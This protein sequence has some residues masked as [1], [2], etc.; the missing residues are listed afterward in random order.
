MDF[1]EVQAQRYPELAGQYEALGNLFSKKLWHELTEVLER[2]VS[3]DAFRREN[4][5]EELYAEFITK[6]ENRLSPIKLAQIV[7]IIGQKFNNAQKSVTFLSSILKS[8]RTKLSTDASLF[9][10]MDIAIA[11]V[12]L[13]DRDAALTS[14]KE[15]WASLSANPSSETVIYSK[16]Y[17]ASSVYRKAF[18]PAVE[19]VRVTLMYLAYAPVESIPA[20]LQFSLATELCVSAISS[21]DIFNFGEVVSTPILK[22]LQST[23][24]EWL[25][26]LVFALNEGNMVKFNQVV[27]TYQKEFMAEAKL[28]A[29][30]A[31]I[32]QKVIL[33]SIMNLVFSRSSHDRNISFVDI[34]KAADIPLKEVEWALMKALSLKLVKGNINEVAQTVQVTWVQP[35]VLSR[36]HIEMLCD[37]LGVWTDKV[38][39]TLTTVEDH[40]TEL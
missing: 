15:T 10:S 20:E 22:S 36:E 13:G 32:K 28:G 8:P 12:E 21:E 9:I 37:Q 35:R 30:L 39:T 11:N 5:L 4:N 33:L 3:D 38:K 23:P 19:F 17:Y 1:V 40:A 6:F 34:A 7:G 27:T 31:V 29:N 25:Y 16:Y 18:G 24:S 14:L 2:F 26:D